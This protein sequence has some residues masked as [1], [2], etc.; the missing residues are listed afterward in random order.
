MSSSDQLTQSL[1]KKKTVSLSPVQK[2]VSFGLNGL[3]FAAH[4]VANGK[5]LSALGEGGDSASAIVSS[6]QSVIVGGTLGLLLGTGLKFSFFVGKGESDRQNAQEVLQSAIYLSQILG[7]VAASALWSSGPILKAIYDREAAEIAADFFKAYA[8]GAFFLMYLIVIPQFAI[9][10]NRPMVPPLVMLSVLLIS[11]G[12][13]YLLGF[14]ASLGA[15]GIGLGGVIGSGVTAL[16]SRIWFSQKEFSV[17]RQDDW[18]VNGFKTWV[19]ELLSLGWKLSLQRLTEWGNLAAIATII[20][21][22]SRTELAAFNPSSLYIVLFGTT[23]QGIGAATGMMIKQLIGMKTQ[24]E[25]AGDNIDQFYRKFKAPIVKAILTGVSFN[26]LFCIAAYVFPDRLVQPFLADQTDSSTRNLSKILLQYHSL[27]MLADSA[28]IVGSG[29]LRGWDALIFPI[30]VRT[31]LM[32]LGIA[33]SF[34]LFE[35]GEATTALSLSYSRDLA[36]AV[37]IPFILARIYQKIEV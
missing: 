14:Q 9:S 30:V 15:T 13:S 36:I 32:T 28:S 12:A 18:R 11:L 4:V 22:Q 33:V 3:F 23:Q 17:Y 35:T 6:T 2:G 19:K 1:I 10:V 27:G 8:A 16:F 34:G 20:G 25:N 26:L 29:A 31:A 21:A 7:L 5:L 24:K 37:S